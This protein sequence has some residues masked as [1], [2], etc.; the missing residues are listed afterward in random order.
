MDEFLWDSVERTMNKSML[1]I[2]DPGP[3]RA[4]IISF[5]LRRNKDLDLVIETTTARHA[6]S[7]TPTRPPGT[8]RRNDDHIR[9]ENGFGFNATGKGTASQF[10]DLQRPPSRRA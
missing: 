4:P 8:L 6:V 5:V 1:R 3:L 9:F 7:S 2:V 10:Q